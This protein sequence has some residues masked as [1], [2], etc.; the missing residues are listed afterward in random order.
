MNY[1]RTM[2]MRRIVIASILK[3]VNDTRAFEK[4]GA[5][6]S[7]TNKYEVNII[8]F[9]TK[10]LPNYPNVR[11]HTDYHFNR[12]SWQ[13]LF[14]GLKFLKRLR[15]LRPSYIVITTHE[16]IIPALFYKLFHST[17]LIYDIQEN[18]VQ[19]ILHT[20][21]FPS[22]IRPILASW[23][24]IKERVSRRFIDHFLLAER[25]YEKELKFTRKKAT[26]LENYYQP[27]T[28]GMMSTPPKVVK[29]EP[30][31]LIFS[32]TLA[33]ETGVFRACDLM[34]N[35][36]QIDPNVTLTIIGYCNKSEVLERLQQLANSS[37][38]IELIGG[39][40]L[41]PHDQIV[42]HLVQAHFGI[43]SY[44]PSQ[45]TKD[46][47]PTKLFEYLSIGLPILLTEHAPWAEICAPYQASINI[48]FETYSARNVLEQMYA[49]HFY[50]NGPSSHFL[51]KNIERQLLNIIQS[52]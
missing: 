25:C 42:N 31:K 33:E 30:I 3:P 21:A 34:N 37:N 39:N 16:L 49:E 13:R 7:K 29:G 35:L 12:L 46:R 8:G 6:L 44:L 18:Y 20:S 32:G 11:F 28:S 40:E 2:S 45:N 22:I 50:P 43:I 5:S 52:L 1:F 9:A 26:V 27:P 15:S 38:H 10:K 51:W 36:Q 48:D 14:A 41:V 4:L 17:I 47:T 24:S 23:V 19:N